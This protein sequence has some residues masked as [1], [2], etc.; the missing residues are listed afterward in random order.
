MFHASHCFIWVWARHFRQIK[1]ENKELEEAARIASEAISGVHT[2]VSFNA[3]WTVLSKFSKLLA[4]SSKTAIWK[5]FITGLAAGGS[6]M[7]VF[8]AHAGS[9]AFGAFLID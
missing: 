1:G 6:Q 9:L 7:S 8:F 2:V 3:E 5:G 4:K